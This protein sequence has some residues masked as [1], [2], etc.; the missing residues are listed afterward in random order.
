MQETKR[1]RVRGKAPMLF[2]SNNIRETHASSPRFAFR[3]GAE[4]QG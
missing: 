3:T 1:R 4:T 2:R